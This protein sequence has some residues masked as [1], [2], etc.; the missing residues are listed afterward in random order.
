MRCLKPYN[1]GVEAYPPASSAR[2][3]TSITTSDM[4]M[5]GHCP[6][7]ASLLRWSAAHGA[8]H[9]HDPPEILSVFV[10]RLRAA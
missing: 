8:R 4:R 9:M 3:V 2:E 7:T 10:A 6:A 5:E 1:T